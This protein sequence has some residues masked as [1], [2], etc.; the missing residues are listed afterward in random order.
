MFGQVTQN[1]WLPSGVVLNLLP[2]VFGRWADGAVT[3]DL[4]LKFTVTF[5]LPL[6]MPVF[7]VNFIVFRF[8]CE[9]KLEI[10]KQ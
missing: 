8:N 3:A 6:Q 10:T 4:L 1:A 2:V 5:A 9:T 7:G